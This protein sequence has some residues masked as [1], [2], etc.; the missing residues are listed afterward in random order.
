MPMS[1][2]SS[3]RPPI[4]HL[5]PKWRFAPGRQ[6]TVPAVFLLMML[7]AACQ[8]SGAGPAS[9]PASQTGSPAHTAR[10]AVPALASDCSSSSPCPIAAG[11]YRLGPGTV[12]PGLEVTVPSGWSSTENTPGDLALVPPGQQNDALYFGLDMVAVK[13]SGAG[14]GTTILKNVGGTPSALTAWLTRDPDFLIVS[15]PAPATIGHRITMTSLVVGVSRSANYGDPG[16]PANPRCADL[17]TNSYW[18]SSNFYGI[19]GNEQVRLYL[20]TIEISGRPHT[21]FV[22]LDAVNHADLLRLEQAANPIVNNVRLPTGVGS[23]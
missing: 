5:A 3:A 15:K 17:F 2:R 22:A 12:L 11:T 13:S 19:G 20:G 23:G 6:H 7:L 8:G 9:P 4:Y 10:P 21:F 1:R 14:H 16:C 18:G